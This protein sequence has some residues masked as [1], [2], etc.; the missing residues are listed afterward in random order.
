M[1]LTRVL[2]LRGGDQFVWQDPLGAEPAL[3][4]VTSGPVDHFG[5]VTVEVKEWDFDFEAIESSEVEVV[6]HFKSD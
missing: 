6:N 2:D 4:T 1:H 5:S 3:L